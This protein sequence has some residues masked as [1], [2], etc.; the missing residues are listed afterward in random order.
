MVSLY[1]EEPKD[2]SCFVYHQ[3]T[4]Q[5]MDFRLSISF[6]NE[7]TDPITRTFHLI[8][9]R[10]AQS[11]NSVLIEFHWY[12]FHCY[13]CPR[14]DLKEKRI[15]LQAKP[16]KVIT[17]LANQRYFFKACA[18]PDKNTFSASAQNHK[19]PFLPCNGVRL[20]MRIQASDLVSQYR[21]ICA[22]RNLGW[23][24]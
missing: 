6:V 21:K 13:M 20:R 23:N 16:L 15:T 9:A 24:L 8:Q 7:C 10:P 11:V 14:P 22:R 17:S 4:V 2:Q 19:N 12:E 3:V 5:I 1:F 18:I